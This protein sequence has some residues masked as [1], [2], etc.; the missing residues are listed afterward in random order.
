[1]PETNPTGN[2]L[3]KNNFKAFINNRFTSQ[4]VGVIDDK[5]FEKYP[6]KIDGPYGPGM[7]PEDIPNTCIPCTA[8]GIV[9]LP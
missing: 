6:F 8:A 3:N 5:F 7:C 4:G 2:E 1:L 9:P